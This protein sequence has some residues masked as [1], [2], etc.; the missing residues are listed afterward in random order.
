[1]ERWT[2]TLG[3]LA[4]LTTV[5]HAGDVRAQEG[6]YS[7]ELDAVEIV[8][9]LDDPLPLDARFVDHRGQNVVLGDYFDGERPVVLNFAYHGCEVLCAMVLD[10]SVDGLKELPWSAGDEYTFV[11][12]SIDP[13]DTPQVAQ[14]TRARLLRRYGRRASNSDFHFLVGEKSEIDSV[15]KAAGFG[16][17]YDSAQDIYAHAATMQLVTPDGRMARYLYGLVFKPNDIRLGLLEASEGRSI[18][19]LEQ[20]L[21]YCYSYDEREGYVLVATR[22]MQ[23]GG[24]FVALVLFGFLSLFWLRELRRRRTSP[25]RS[26]RILKRLS[27]PVTEA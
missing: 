10:A 17:R 26:N 22:V 2:R 8:E 1:M 9:H 20:V 13:N 27:E 24:G 11:S 25:N 5:S 14:E 19:T 21:V 4:V 7:P 18:S 16:Y 6:R 15:A 23:I 12:I 3:L